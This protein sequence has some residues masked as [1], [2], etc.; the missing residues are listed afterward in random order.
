[1][2][3]DNR[4]GWLLAIVVVMSGQG[5]ASETR[6]LQPGDRAPAFTLPALAERR[7]ISL[8]EYHGK[9]VYLDFWSS[10]CAPCREAFPQ[11]DALR[12]SL[13][14]DEFEVIGINLEQS[15]D[16][17]RRF[18]R[19]HPVSFPIVSDA[20]LSLKASYGVSVMPSSFLIDREGIVRAAHRGWVVDDLARM[21]RQAR[22]LIETEDQG[23]GRP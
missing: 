3:Q 22:H 16:D 10:W 12:E 7:V 17:A 6:V 1:M 13:P 11:L 14:R 23:A 19:R 4:W 2:R 21:A 8:S 20:A 9:V 15:A 5:A 18:L